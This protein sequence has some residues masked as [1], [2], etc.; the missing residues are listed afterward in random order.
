MPAALGPPDRV[1]IA[2]RR[3][4]LIYAPRGDLAKLED[5]DAGLILT[6]VR[7]GIRGEYLRKLVFGGTSVRSARV[8]GH[9]GAFISGGPHAYIY[10]NPNGVIEEDHTLL[11]GPTLIWEQGGLVLRMETT[12]DRRKALQIAATSER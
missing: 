4:S 2:G 7:G 6:E 12:A 3:L 8:D 1:R 9:R 11:A 10:E 5:V